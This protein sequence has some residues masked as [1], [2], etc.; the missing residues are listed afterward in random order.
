[1]GGFTPTT[2]ATTPIRHGPE[3]FFEVD[4]PRAR[5]ARELRFGDGRLDV[6]DL[7]LDFGH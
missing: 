5:S 1:M 4:P 3:K 7:E 2:N 6:V